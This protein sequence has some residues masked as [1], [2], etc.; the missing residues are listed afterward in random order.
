MVFLWNLSMTYFSDS[1]NAFDTCSWSVKYV[2]V[3]TNQSDEIFRSQLLHS[4]N[5][6]WLDFSRYV[7]VCLLLKKT[8]LYPKCW[9]VVI[10]SCENSDNLLHLMR[11]FCLDVDLTS[12]NACSSSTRIFCAWEVRGINRSMSGLRWSC[13]DICLPPVFPPLHEMCLHHS[14]LFTYLFCWWILSRS[15]GRSVLVS[16][17]CSHGTGKSIS[18]PLIKMHS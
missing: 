6:F 9:P 14:W 11:T 3:V 7:Q 16:L 12:Y 17:K 13:V 1:V 10:C 8:R 18:F 2:C 15:S 5:S 4:C